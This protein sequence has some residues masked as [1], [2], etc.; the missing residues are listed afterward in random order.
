MSDETTPPNDIESSR[1]TGKHSPGVPKLGT[2]SPADTANFSEQQ[3][4]VTE[5]PPSQPKDLAET[6]ASSVVPSQ[7]KLPSGFEVTVS[8]NQADDTA[9]FS[10]DKTGVKANDPD[11]TQGFSQP[12]GVEHST[13]IPGYAILGELGR[14]AMGV[15]YKAKQLRADRTVALKMMLNVD[16]ARPQEVSRFEVEAKASAQLIHPGIVQVFDVG[17]AKNVPYFTQEFVSGGTLSSRISKQ[18]LSHVDTTKMILA[19]TKAVAYAHSR[20]II[21]RDLKP[22]NILIGDDG[23]P[24]IADFGLARRMEDQSHLTKDG[25]ILG[26]PSYMAPEQAYGSTHEIGPLS[27]VYALGAILYELLVGR[28]PFKGATVWEV[29]ELVRRA[30]PTPPSELQPGIPRDLETICLKCLQKDP[31]RRYGSAQALAD[32]IQR[33]L[34]NEPI[35]ARPVGRWERFVRL[36]KRHPGE[37]RLVAVVVAILLISA[38]GAVWTAVQINSQKQIAEGRLKLAKDTVSTVVNQLQH[39]LRDLPHSDGVRTRL[40][41]AASDLFLASGES[42]NRDREIATAADRGRLAFLIREAE[43]ALQQ[44]SRDLAEVETRIAKAIAMAKADYELPNSDRG[45]TAFNYAFALSLNAVSLSL[46]G[47]FDDQEA[48]REQIEALAREGVSA[49][50]SQNSPEV[51]RAKLGHHLLN[52]ADY[53]RSRA[54]GTP[55]ANQRAE[56]LKS[57][58]SRSLEAVETL[59]NALPNLNDDQ[60]DRDDFERDL[61]LAARMNALIGQDLGD[62]SAIDSGFQLAITTLESLVARRPER[63]NYRNNLLVCC[64]EYGD[65]LMMAVQK[66]KEAAEQYGKVLTQIRWILGESDPAL[67]VYFTPNGD[68]A[69]TYYRL[70]LTSHFQKDDAARKRYFERCVNIQEIALRQAEDLPANK[71]NPDALLPDRQVLM[72][73]QAWAGQVESATESAKWMVERF[74][75]DEAGKKHPMAADSIVRCAFSMAMVAKELSGDARK[76][77]EESALK[78]LTASIDLGYRDLGYLLGD[79]DAEA[80]R[81]ISGFEKVVAPLRKP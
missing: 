47:K 71:E 70:G 27:D 78:L 75:K 58:N 57:A 61:A 13:V 37:A 28:T 51:R 8:M 59:Q 50:E 19:I 56:W 40:A 44:P 72:L 7:T 64:R 62:A 24:K 74:L 11:A 49:S 43:S 55:D 39:E 41:Q 6:I 2:D 32:D 77:K 31:A 69:M 21:H 46:Q 38:L 66:P 52:S 34:N 30:E 42:N 16:H 3:G 18:L 25:S 73:S 54:L 33:Y 65:H 79:P 68:W 23:A 26:T 53:F 45:I 1:P 22:S 29:I 60:D 12:M 17:M 9:D 80:L 48:I 20:G 81:T 35:Q 10:T 14:G 4:A 63:I 36:C 5:N 76:A 67:R 15:V